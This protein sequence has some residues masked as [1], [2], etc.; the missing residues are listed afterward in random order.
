MADAVCWYFHDPLSQ[1]GCL[2]RK[3][4]NDAKDVDNAPEQCVDRTHGVDHPGNDTATLAC[5]RTA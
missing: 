2:Q 3:D 5:H 1:N 4:A